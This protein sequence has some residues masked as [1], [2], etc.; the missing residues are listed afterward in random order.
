MAIRYFC[1]GFID[2]ASPKWF[3]YHGN[4]E[5]KMDDLP[6]GKLT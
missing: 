6:S 1:G 4:S 2:G 5:N 3:V